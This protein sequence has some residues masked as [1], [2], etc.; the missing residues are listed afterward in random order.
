MA[1]FTSK[2]GVTPKQVQRRNES[3]YETSQILK[4]INLETKS[5]FEGKSTLET[6]LPS[7]RV[8]HPRNK[9]DLETI[10]LLK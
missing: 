10:P 5:S 4:Q 6:S 7:K 1:F 2:E 8:H 3:S 9:S